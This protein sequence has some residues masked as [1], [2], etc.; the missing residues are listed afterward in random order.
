MEPFKVRLVHEE[1][2]L[3]TKLDGLEKFLA[4]E[5]FS[6]FPEVQRD[7]LFKQHAAM[8]NYHDILSL[9]M[10]NL[11]IG[12]ELTFGQKAAGVGF[13]PGGN[14]VVEFTKDLYAEVID[15]LNNCKQEY[16]E[17]PQVARYY[18]KAVSYAED[19]QMNAVKAIT[20]KD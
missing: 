11:G 5:G 3:R 17:S 19:S 13:N 2:Q 8:K 9:R 1:K 12:T 6:K 20:W 16:L 10:T 14:P 18:S 15:L 4:S 7:L